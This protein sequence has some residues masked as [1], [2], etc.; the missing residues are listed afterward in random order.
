MVKKFLIILTIVVIALGCK[1][2]KNSPIPLVNVDIF[3][4]TTDPSF[5]DLNA[6]GGWTYINGGSRGILI[7][8]ASNNEFKAYDRHCTYD[9]ANSCALVSVETNNITALDNCC[10]SRFLINDG[11][12]S[13]GPANLPLKQYQTSFDGSVLHIFN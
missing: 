2:D 10:G 5:I 7:Y 6:V 8:R 4:H 11:S 1:K 3:I 12:V 9:S 13:N